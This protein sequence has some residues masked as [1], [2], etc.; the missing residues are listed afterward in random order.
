MEYKSFLM[1]PG[2]Y[3][4]DV[5][6]QPWLSNFLPGAMNGRAQLLNPSMD[7]EFCEA[8]IDS[9]K[10]FM[11]KETDSSI[12]AYT[13]TV[14]STSKS[15]NVGW[16]NCWQCD[17]QIGSGQV[18]GSDAKAI[19]EEH[20]MGEG[21]WKALNARI[22][23]WANDLEDAAKRNNGDLLASLIRGPRFPHWWVYCRSNGFHG[24]VFDEGGVR[25]E[26]NK[27]LEEM[28]KLIKTMKDAETT[29]YTIFTLV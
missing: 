17:Y 23:Q 19:L 20:F 14:S 5:C 9:M 11:S 27:D 7:A 21:L 16:D 8:S 24:A 2:G 26:V 29:R 10:E 28:D 1:E 3:S 12:Q 6:Y 13:R 18:S 22:Q 25:V 15:L 4:G